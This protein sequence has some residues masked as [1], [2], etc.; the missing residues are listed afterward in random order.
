[1]EKLRISHVDTAQTKATT[2][3]TETFSQSCQQTRYNKRSTG[4]APV[5][6]ITIKAT[7]VAKAVQKVNE[8]RRRKSMRHVHKCQNTAHP[9]N[10]HEVRNKLKAQREKQRY[11]SCSEFRNKKI[12][13]II[14]YCDEYRKKKLATI[15]RYYANTN[16]QNKVRANKLK[17]YKTDVHFQE[18]KRKCV[19]RRY[20]ADAV[21][22]S[23]QKKY[24]V[25]K[26]KDTSV[27]EDIKEIHVGQVC[28]GQGLQGK[29]ETNTH[30]VSHRQT[31]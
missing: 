25:E 10:E 14:L 26:Y 12:L 8:L 20:T 28:T 16:A 27:R 15:K 24:I 5:Q 6:N 19:V 17:K 9:K 22:Q 2:S 29:K 18:K 21:F 7:N 3:Q 13:A 23:R 11:D 4:E 30:Q 1:M 31:F